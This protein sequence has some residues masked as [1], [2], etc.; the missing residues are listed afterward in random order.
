MTERPPAA[1]EAAVVLLKGGSWI[2]VKAFHHINVT[3]PS[4][5]IYGEGFNKRTTRQFRGKLHRSAIDSITTERG[6]I[7]CWLEDGASV[8][9]RN[10]Y[11]VEVTSAEGTGFWCVGKYPNGALFRGRVAH[12][13]ISG[14]QTGKFDVGKTIS[15]AAIGIGIILAILAIIGFVFVRGQVA[16]F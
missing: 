3:E 1:N 11:Y 8:L 5:F 10:R 4:D 9:F 2:E 6:S 15:S 16:Q 7:I 14:F 12:E 13:D